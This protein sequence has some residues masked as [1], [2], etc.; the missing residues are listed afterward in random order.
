[1][2]TDVSRNVVVFQ[3]KRWRKESH[4][5]A[6][7]PTRADDCVQQAWAQVRA[8][9][10]AEAKHVSALHSEWEPSANDLAFIRKHFPKATF[11]Y[12]FRRPGPDGWEAAFAAARQVIAEAGASKAKQGMRHV[13][14]RGELLPVLWSGSSPKR[15]ML[16]HLPHHALVPG[17]LFVTLATVAPTPHGTIGMNHVTHAG[18]EGRR[19]ADLMGEAATN[20]AQGLQIEGRSDPARPDKGQLVVLRRTGPFAASA[21]ALP[22]FR[23]RV[24]ALTGSDDLLAGVPEP[25]T[26]VLTGINSGWAAEVEQAVLRSPCEPGEM[27]PTLLSLTPAGIQIEAERQ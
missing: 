2:D 20:L 4:A 11:T 7:G 26:L 19:F 3:L 10:N 21:L 25:D 8:E 15:M 5:I 1:V 18:L 12:N 9:N 14:E 24:A 23:E 6:D 22:G 13:A 17:R 27:V 16:E